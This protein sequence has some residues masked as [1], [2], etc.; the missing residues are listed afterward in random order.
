MFYYCRKMKSSELTRSVRSS[1]AP[2]IAT[3]PSLST[4]ER[5]PMRLDRV[6]ASSMTSLR[7]SV[8]ADLHNKCY[9]R[10]AFGVG[11]EFQV[12]EHGT[13]MT[14]FGLPRRVVAVL[15]QMSPHADRLTWTVAEGSDAVSLALAWDFTAGGTVADNENGR[16]EHQGRRS[17]SCGDS[18]RG[19]TRVGKDCADR[20]AFSDDDDGK[21]NRR[22]VVPSDA[23]EEETASC[24][25]HQRLNG[26]DGGT[27][28]SFRLWHR[29][30]TLTALRRPITNDHPPRSGSSDEAA[31]NTKSKNDNQSVAISGLRHRWT[32]TVGNGNDVTCGDYNLGAIM[33][34]NANCHVT[35]ERKVTTMSGQLETRSERTSGRHQRTFLRCKNRLLD[36]PLLRRLRVARRPRTVTSST[37]TSTSGQSNGDA[38]INSPGRVLLTSTSLPERIN[39]QASVSAIVGTRKPPDREC[40]DGAMYWYQ[41]SHEL[42]QHFQLDVSYSIISDSSELYPFLASQF[43]GRYVEL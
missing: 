13:G 31:T 41:L 38:D 20:D 42:Q 10:S 43:L 15:R 3:F 17:T 21:R 12:E 5:L 27:R 36:L 35:S 39:R 33:T 2:T 24:G 22:H 6:P 37:V 16:R 14:P 28:V 8:P 1:T 34:T 25:V 18:R 7:A 29:L 40:S 11:D 9:D 19:L 23:P 26:Q 4:R 32:S 30:R